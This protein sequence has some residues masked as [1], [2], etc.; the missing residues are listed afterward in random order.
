MNDKQNASN[1]NKF[2]LDFVYVWKEKSPFLSKG[3][4]TRLPDKVTEYIC[5]ITNNFYVCPVVRHHYF[6]YGSLLWLELFTL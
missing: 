6:S 3:E 1:H 2:M 4:D 5:L